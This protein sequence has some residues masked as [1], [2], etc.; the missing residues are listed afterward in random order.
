MT[1]KGLL[2]KD[3]QTCEPV[4]NKSH[5]SA[6]VR[7]H[8]NQLIHRCLTKTTSTPNSQAGRQSDGYGRWCLELRW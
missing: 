1:N 7:S 4:T 8:G 5:S 6:V 3:T 2:N